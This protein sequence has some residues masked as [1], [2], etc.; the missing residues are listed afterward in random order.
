M[1]TSP[2]S[3]KSQK[4]FNSYFSI[5]TLPTYTPLKGQSNDCSVQLSYQ[6]NMS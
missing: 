1:E 4:K 2:Q 6:V 5:G 3:T